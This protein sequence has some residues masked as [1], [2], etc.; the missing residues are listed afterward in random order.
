MAVPEAASEQR[1]GWAREGVRM[2]IISNRLESI[3]RKMQNTLFRTARSGVLNTAHDFSCV[4]LTADCQ[5]LAS[6]ESLPIHTLIGP[7]IMCETVKKYHPTLKAGD[8]FLHNSPYEGDS[9]PADHCLIVPVVDEGGTLRFFVLAKAHQAD[10]GNSRPTTYMGH[11]VDVYEEGALIFSAAK[12]QSEYKNNEDLIRMCRSRIRVPEQWWGDYLATL[13]AVRIGERELLG[14]GAEVGWETLDQYS[15]AWFDYSEKKMID[16]IG[17]LPSGKVT[18]HS[19]HDPFPGVPDGIPVKVDVEIDAAAGKIVVDLRDNIDC[20]PCG[21]NLSEGCARTAAMVGIYNGILDHSVPANAGSFRRVEVL[22]RENCV[23]GIPRH[24]HSCSVATTNLADRVA[25]PVQRAMAEI[26]PGFGMAETGPIMPP[27]MGVISGK[28]PRHDDAPFVNQ[29][30]LGCTG[31]AGTPVTDGFLSIIHV[32]NA[33]LCR[34]DSIEVD[35]L[36]HPVFVKR[37]EILADTEGAGE[38]RGAPSAYAEFGPV[39]GCT[40]DVLYTADGTINPALGAQGGGPGAL[41]QALK[42][43]LDGSLTKL[44]ACYGVTLRPGEYVVSR[45]SGGGGYG[46]PCNRA[47]ERVLHDVREGWVTVERAR[48]VYGV[49]VSGEG[50]DLAVDEAAT[51]ARRAAMAA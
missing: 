24:P 18:V 6:A 42:R 15:A 13:G 20:Q 27:A 31:G 11:A 44:P 40:M 1:A 37:R 19:A 43:E 32:G 51:A 26:A 22:L 35:E 38:F 33:G 14:L 2:A 16:A 50:Q 25:N 39:E 23:V 3:A 30:F 4:V 47:P 29:I 8:C 45:S 9:H 41:S 10:C 34:Q 46:L 17:R 5:L 48:D 36:H 21:L 7:D 49:V 12:I 28:D